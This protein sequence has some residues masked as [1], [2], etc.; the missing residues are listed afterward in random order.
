MFFI[1]IAF[2]IT[3][4]FAQRGKDGP[5]TITTSVSV[6]EYTT[7]TASV[8]VG[9]TTLPVAA[10]TLNANAR[11]ASNLAP[12]DLV[13]IYQV[14]GTFINGYA[15]GTIGLPNDSTWGKPTDYYT[16]GKYE[17]AEVSAVPNSTSITLDCGL[18]NNYDFNAW[19]FTQLWFVFQ[20]IHR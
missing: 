3:M 9:T 4:L 20:D 1:L 8:A 14:R 19:F 15:S 5:R 10:S 11:F 12:G 13:M 7:L 17:F 2:P 16:T 18:T 6:N